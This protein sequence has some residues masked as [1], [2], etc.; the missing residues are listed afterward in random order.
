MM[1]IT[2]SGVWRIASLRRLIKEKLPTEFVLQEVATYSGLGL[3]RR[4]LRQHALPR[5]HPDCRCRFIRH[6]V[7]RPPSAPRRAE[8]VRGAPGE[9]RCP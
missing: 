8:P 1:S 7:R 3:F 5:L 2:A 9:G 6:T 4:Y